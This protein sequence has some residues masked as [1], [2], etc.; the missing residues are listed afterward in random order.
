MY[1]IHIR[2]YLHNITV[3]HSSS[4]CIVVVINK[5]NV[6]TMYGVHEAGQLTGCH[7]RRARGYGGKAY[8][9]P[10]ARGHQRTEE[11]YTEINKKKI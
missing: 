9:L 5:N 2:N 6:H 1:T 8:T 10:Y 7:Y 11:P 4:P 3:L